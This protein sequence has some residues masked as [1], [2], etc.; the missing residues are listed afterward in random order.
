MP[1]ETLPEQEVE[2]QEQTS[3]KKLPPYH[4]ILHNDDDHS[5]P[6][7]INMLQKLFGIP[8]EKGHRMAHEIHEKG[9]V[10]CVTTSKEHAELK[11]E[12]IHAWGPDKTIPRCQGSMTATIEPAA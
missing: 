2:E 7:V 12:Q 6:Y 1:V 4:V 5:F 9:K 11:Q 10:I 3:T 8:V